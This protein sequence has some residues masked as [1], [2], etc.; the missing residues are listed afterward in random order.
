[1]YNGRTR[2]TGNKLIVPFCSPLANIYI[3]LV[4]LFAISFCHSHLFQNNN[5]NKKLYI[6]LYTYIYIEESIIA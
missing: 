2:F 6:S 5:N 1:M 4:P 3:S